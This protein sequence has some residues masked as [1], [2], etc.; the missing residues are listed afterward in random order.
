MSISEV[1]ESPL[2][3]R[4]RDH[5]EAAEIVRRAYIPHRLNT[6][7][8][9]PLNFE[10][11]SIE[12]SRMTIGHLKYGSPVELVAPPMSTAYHLNLP[13]QGSSLGRQASEE[14]VSRPKERGIIFDPDQ[15]LGA[16]WDSDTQLYAIK[17]ARGALDDHAGAI[18]GH[19]I[20][21]GIKFQLSFSV[22]SPVG[23][24]LVSAVRYLRKEVCREGGIGNSRIL[25]GQLES[26]VMTQM[27]LA[28]PN[29]FTS[30]LTKP[31]SPPKRRRYLAAVIDH[32]AANPLSPLSL[33]D[34]SKIA[35][36]SARALQ[37]GF[38]EEL[39]VSPMA[40]VRNVRLERA[41]AE[42]QEAR[43][44]DSVTDIAL[45]WGFTHLSRFSEYYKRRYGVLPSQTLNNS[46][47]V[48]GL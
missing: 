30:A 31:A 32:V 45:R 29:N 5:D 36:V 8:S 18:L 16:V 14:V 11:H 25:R 48:T 23:Q 7:S 3:T 44:G 40:Y 37:E 17:V 20:D 43:E 28:I 1:Y 34:L 24:G 13:I 33:P 10:L 22:A 12:S 2:T 15:P 21:T 35:G 46:H 39:G 6:L 38:Q 47:K 26:Y 42:L 27:L 41:H 9:Q 19:P 4:T